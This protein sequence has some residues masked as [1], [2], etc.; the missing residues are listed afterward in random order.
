MEPDVIIGIMV[1]V[2]ALCA[3]LYLVLRSCLVIDHI[4]KKNLKTVREIKRELSRGK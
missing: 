3:V 1:I 4:S 2:F